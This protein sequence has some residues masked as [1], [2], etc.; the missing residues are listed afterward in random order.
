L[1]P[2]TY[3]EQSSTFSL[4]RLA[5]WEYFFPFQ[6]PQIGRRRACWILLARLTPWKAWLVP[7]ILTHVRF[8]FVS[9]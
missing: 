6:I 5:A 4:G 3:Q 7:W 1:R 9:I 2:A 8:F